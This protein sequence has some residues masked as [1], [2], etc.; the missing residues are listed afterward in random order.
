M[1]LRHSG[2]RFMDLA[3]HPADIEAQLARR[4]FDQTGHRVSPSELRSWSGSLP[5]LAD[6][7]ND[8]GLGA[9]EVLVEYQLPLTSRRADVVLAGRNPRT[10]APSYVVVELKQWSSVEL[11]PESPELVAVAAAPGGPRL[12]PVAQ[13]RR[14]RDYMSDFLGVAHRHEDAIVGAAYLHNAGVDVET[15]L[16]SYPPDNRARL[17][18]GA[19]RGQFIDYL[20]SR[21]D[22]DVAGAPFADQLLRSTVAPSRQLLSV[23]ADELDHREQFV[24]LDE[25]RVAVDL[26]LASVEQARS[27]DHKSVIVVQGG[28]GSGKSVI[29]LSLMGELAARGRTVVHATGSKAFTTTLRKLSGRRNQRAT[30]LFKYFNSFM[31]AE[32]NGL[33]VL[34]LDEAHRIRRTSENRYTRAEHRTGRPQVDELLA[35]ARVPVFLLDEHQVVRPGEMGTIQGIRDSA[36][37]L[38]LQVHVVSLR[39]QFR[40]GGSE[41]YE[42]WVMD[43]LGLGDRGPWVWAGDGRF[44][45]DVV[46]SPAELEAR[47]AAQLSDGYSARMTAGY[48][49][50]WSNPRRDGTLVADVQI[51]GWGRPWNLKGDRALPGAPSSSLWASQPAGFHQVGCVYTAQGFEY[52]WNGV[53]IGP[54]LVWRTGRW[55]SRREF[56]RDPDLRSRTSVSD[57]DF[58]A[59]VR[60]VYK[61]LLTRGMIGTLIYSTDPETREF[62]AGIAGTRS[63]ARGGEVTPS[64]RAD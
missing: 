36:L 47:L 39:D 59:L 53:I 46:S 25:Q 19:S 61:V 14:Y 45:V 6:A 33:D 8:A 34:V 58:D 54:D 23:V 62:L 17:F 15:T 64:A 10:G 60:N 3:W 48:C 38:G 28:P 49:W 32:R 11:W 52:D 1:L 35:A 41:L 7:L 24:L 37:R 50:P 55:V 56:N 30:A 22:A 31:Q 21:L 57:E 43:L 4:Y 51:D 20:R 5:I 63:Q 2:R 27:G 26:V 42:R 40:C 29:A 18:T 16:G 13:V 9:V 12:H 44:E